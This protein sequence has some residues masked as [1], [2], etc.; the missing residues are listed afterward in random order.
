MTT[1]ETI[2]HLVKLV[3]I[4][5]TADNRHAIAQAV[6]YMADFI[7]DRTNVTF[8]WFEVNGRPSFL[9]Y[10]GPVRPEKFIV[11]LNAHVDVVSADPE[12]FVVRQ[13]GERLYGRGVLDMKGTALVLADL[14]CDLV[15]SVDYPLGFQVVGDE[16][17]SGPSAQHQITEGVRS[18]I[19]F[20]AEYANNSATIYNAARGMLWIEVAFKGRAAH[21][22]HPWHG[23]NAVMRAALFARKLHKKFPIPTKETWTTTA[24]IA[25]VATPNTTYNKVPDYATMRIDFRFTEK[26]TLFGDEQ[27][28]RAFV[29]ELDP[30]AEVIGISGYGP[31]VF[32][33][34]DNPLVQGLAAAIRNVTGLEAEYKGRPASSDGRHFA[35]AGVASLEFGLVGQG[36]HSDNEYLEIASIEQY[37]NIMEAFLKNPLK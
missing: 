14:F 13:E 10:R 1:K 26:D 9:A 24:N 27:A 18:E 31:A 37:R 19:A 12:M 34:Q 20:T 6:Q 2:D 16:E 22:G 8:E 5:S 36:A 3:A 28:L 33:P 35:R 7:A 4:P 21:G 11:L 29:A 25:S 15:N 32:V 30:D 17:T 23:K